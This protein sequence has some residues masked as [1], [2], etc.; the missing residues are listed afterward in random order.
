VKRRCGKRCQDPFSGDGEVISNYR[1]RPEAIRLK[2]QCKSNSVKVYDKQGS[3]LPVETTINRPYDFKLY[4]PKE[5]DP[6]GPLDW[7]K[8]RQGIADLYLRAQVSGQSNERYLEAL[9]S[10]DTGRPLREIL[11]PVCRRVRWKGRR[12]RALR[13]WSEQDRTLLS[14]NSRVCHQWVPQSRPAGTTVPPDPLPGN[15]KSGG[16]RRELP[17]GSVSCRRAASSERYPILIAMYSRARDAKSPPP[18]SSL[19]KLRCNN[20]AGSQHENLCANYR[21]HVSSAVQRV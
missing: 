17:R 3:I 11:A 10:L 6:N 4:W 16:H 12:M 20:L 14:A 9:T 18:S 13:P 15:K 5:G 7:R 1:K 19:N 8:M 2:H 21:L